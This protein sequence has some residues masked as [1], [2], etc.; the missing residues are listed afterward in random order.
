[1]TSKRSERFGFLTVE[2]SVH[3]RF[4]K[5]CKREGRVIYRVV[6]EALEEYLDRHDGKEKEGGSSDRVV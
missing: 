5:Y 3:E 4:R 1:M 6:Q 2:K